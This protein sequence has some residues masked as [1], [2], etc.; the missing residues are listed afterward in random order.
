MPGSAAAH[1]INFSHRLILTIADI[2]AASTLARSKPPAKLLQLRFIAEKAYVKLTSGTPVRV[3]KKK[4]FHITTAK[5]SGQRIGKITRSMKGKL[6]AI[7]LAK[8]ADA[9]QMAIAKT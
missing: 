9:K 5:S 7:S 6:C 8:A 4:A 3:P 1:H 2:A